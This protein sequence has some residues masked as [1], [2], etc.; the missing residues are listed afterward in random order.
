MKT[1]YPKA[2]LL[3][4]LAGADRRLAANER[5]RTRSHD[6]RL[7]HVIMTESQFSASAFARD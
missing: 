4:T 5:V 1:H 7:R 6:L 3:M 2:S